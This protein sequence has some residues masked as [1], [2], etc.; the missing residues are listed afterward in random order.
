MSAP[1]FALRNAK[2]YF[3]IEEPE[4]A[5]YWFWN[6]TKEDIANIAVNRH[7]FEW[8][9][10]DDI[11]KQ[12]E[13]QDNLS[14]S[15]Y[16]QTLPCYIEKEYTDQLGN[17]WS[18]MLVPMVRNGYFAHACL[19]YYIRLSSPD[20]MYTLDNEDVYETKYVGAFIED[21][22]SWDAQYGDE[23]KTDDMVTIGVQLSR[24]VKSLE[25]QFYAWAEDCGIDE[26]A[27]A[28]QCSNGEA[29]YTNLS[30]IKRK[31]AA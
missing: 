1:N 16:A 6:D 30:E 12:I 25:D 10:N 19:D 23:Y 21:F 8:L 24:L 22:C 18:A 7:G 28:W 31:A 14:G 11:R 3:I 15:Y 13:R 26:Y 20:E 27:K 4:D 17:T 29:G 9:E 2:R 5:D